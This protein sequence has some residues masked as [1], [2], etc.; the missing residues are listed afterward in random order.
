MIHLHDEMERLKKI[1]ESR[2]QFYD[3]MIEGERKMQRILYV[4]LFF[5]ILH[6][7]GIIGQMCSRGMR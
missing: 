5:A 1:H 6:V 2:M 7:I 4:G 3:R